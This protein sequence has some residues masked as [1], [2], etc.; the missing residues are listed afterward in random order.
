[1]TR[2]RGVPKCRGA[3]VFY[4]PGDESE[5]AN[6]KITSMPY[7]R[8]RKSAIYRGSANRLWMPDANRPCVERLWIRDKSRIYGDGR[9]SAIHR[10]SA[11]RLRM[12]D[13]YRPCVE[14]LWIRDKSRIYG[15]VRKSAIHRGSAN[16]LRM[17]DADRPCVERLRIRDE[18]R[19]HGGGT[20]VSV[21][22]RFIADQPIV[23]GCRTRIG[24]VLNGYGYAMNRG[25][26][27]C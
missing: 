4:A 9:K 5:Q 15:G 25:S 23:F 2:I 20:V 12:P 8:N 14:W 17:P 24:R 16:R 1:M 11:N 13:A 22:P 10:G 26:A 7:P 3:S 18:S 21:N 27:V 6:W 19:I